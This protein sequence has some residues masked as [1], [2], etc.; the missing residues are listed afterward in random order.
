M[1]NMASTE[2]CQ[3]IRRTPAIGGEAVVSVKQAVFPYSDESTLH[4]DFWC[5]LVDDRGQWLYKSYE[6][7]DISIDQSTAFHQTMSLSCC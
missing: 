1:M 6:D 4:I 5:W 2:N 3:A 7:T